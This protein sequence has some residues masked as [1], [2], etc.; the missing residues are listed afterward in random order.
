MCAPAVRCRGIVRG[1]GACAPRLRAAAS[2]GASGE[3]FP[4][5]IPA[6]GR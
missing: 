3:L 1:P 2:Y 4:A 6:P 5:H